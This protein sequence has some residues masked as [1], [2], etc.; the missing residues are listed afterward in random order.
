MIDIL[1]KITRYR[2]QMDWSEY[3][4]AKAAN[5]PQ[6]TISTWYRKKIL[7]SFNSLEKICDAFGITL[8]QFFADD[9]D[10]TTLS[11]AQTEIL[12]CWSRL[13]RQQQERLLYFLESIVSKV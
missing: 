11:P 2:L 6:S 1:G 10:L 3:Q 8:S 5:L 7:P 9:G 4:L 12:I 13:D